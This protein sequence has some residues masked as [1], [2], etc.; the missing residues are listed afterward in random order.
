MGRELMIKSEIIVIK[1][2]HEIKIPKITCTCWLY[3]SKKKNKMSSK[4]SFEIIE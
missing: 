2:Y 3:L 4:L 1:Q